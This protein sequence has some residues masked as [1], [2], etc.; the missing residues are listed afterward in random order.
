LTFV[1]AT[2]VQHSSASALEH[3]KFKGE[4]VL[5]IFTSTDGCIQ[6]QVFVAATQGV[7]RSLPGPGNPV[8]EVALF[9]L[10]EDIC[11][12]TRLISAES[13][14]AIPAAD[15]QVDKK[16]AQAILNTTVTATDYAADPPASFDVS[17]DL[18]W[19]ATGPL[20]RAN[21]NTHFHTPGCVIN[22]RIHGT[23]RTAEASGSVSDGTTNYI[24][25][26]STQAL[27]MSSNNGV[28]IIGCTP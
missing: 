18:T 28:L 3:F 26:P 8:T 12:D 24:T 4:S 19:T 14:S 20:T 13:L 23:S 11:T 15:F 9:I 6:T 7:S 22:N 17:I 1:L 10:Q 2:F 27:T 16:L 5:S 25:G 21:D